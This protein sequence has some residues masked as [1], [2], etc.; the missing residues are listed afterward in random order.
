MNN[1]CLSNIEQFYFS[2][3]KWLPNQKKL[4]LM[5]ESCSMQNNNDIELPEL[6]L[7]PEN[8]VGGLHWGW[9]MF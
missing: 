8:G 3:M 2:L 5:D 9:V 6:Q 4:V 1:L 7:N